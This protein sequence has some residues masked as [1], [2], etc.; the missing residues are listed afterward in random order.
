MIGYAA[1][2]EQTALVSGMNVI[3]M[4]QPE[5]DNVMNATAIVV[6]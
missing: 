1:G 4:A 5:A 3:V 2:V 6:E